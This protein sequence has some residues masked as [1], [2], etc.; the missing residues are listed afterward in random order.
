MYGF[1]SAAAAVF[2]ATGNPGAGEVGRCLLDLQVPAAL[3]ATENRSPAFGFLPQALACGARH[4]LCDDLDELAARLPWGEGE[5][6]MPA[7]FVGRF[8]FVEIVGPEGL[9]ADE[10]IKLGLYLQSPNT[11]YPPHAHAAEELYLPLSGTAL[12]QQGEGDFVPRAP[13]ELIHHQSW[14][15]HA[16]QTGDQPLLAMWA[17]RGNLS[18]ADYSI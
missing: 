2:R 16:M 15:S 6:N 10:R 1:L 8:A 7:S 13:G 11:Y 4:E 14:E 12:W 3:P 17:W 5:F 18:T 9:I